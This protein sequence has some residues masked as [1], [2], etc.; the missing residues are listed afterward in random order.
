MRSQP[1]KP[2]AEV[3]GSNA[4]VAPSY[5]WV[6]LDDENAAEQPHGP[7]SVH[8]RDAD[9]P[10]EIDRIV[11]LP[12]ATDNVLLGETDCDVDKESSH[13]GVSFD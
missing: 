12:S 6:T 13:D 4:V 9:A 11:D 2:A 7:S 8:L 1:D 10:A 3:S 5:R